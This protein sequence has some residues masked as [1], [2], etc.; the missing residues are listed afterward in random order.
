MNRGGGREGG[1]NV[2]EWRIERNKQ[3]KKEVGSNVTERR[4]ERKKSM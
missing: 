4:M 1:K 2:R 3:G